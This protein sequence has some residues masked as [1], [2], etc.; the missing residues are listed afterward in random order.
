MHSHLD[1]GERGRRAVFSASE[2]DHAIGGGV[3]GGH[4]R[5]VLSS[6]VRDT[7]GHP[8]GT[9]TMQPAQVRGATTVGLSHDS[10]RWLGSDTIY[11]NSELPQNDVSGKGFSGSA[12]IVSARELD[13][14]DNAYGTG[15]SPAPQQQALEPGAY[16][17]TDGTV[18]LVHPNGQRMVISMQQYQA[19]IAQQQ[20]QIQ[21]PAPAYDPMQDIL[22]RTQ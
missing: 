10:S 1:N 5:I 16:E 9:E 17:Q 12:H 8:G 14:I 19:L 3:N 11:A 13:Q 20:Q 18:L 15:P 2:I 22:N 7:R 4:G 6:Q 21:E